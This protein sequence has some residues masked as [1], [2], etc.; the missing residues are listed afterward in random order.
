MEPFGFKKMT[1][2]FDLSE[3][4]V[5][6]LFVGK[7]IVEIL[8]G[9]KRRNLILLHIISMLCAWLLKTCLTGYCKCFYFECSE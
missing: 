6:G 7:P 5:R 2:L 9:V 8:K 1:T 3:K 4:L